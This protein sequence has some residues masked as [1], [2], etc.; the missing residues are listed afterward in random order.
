MVSISPKK[1]IRV[2]ID[3][4]RQARDHDKEERIEQ[5][6]EESDQ[7]KNVDEEEKIKITCF[8]DESRNKEQTT[9]GHRTKNGITAL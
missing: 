4:V 3:P 6:E 9:K 2:Q 8:T 7:E 1:T 5:I